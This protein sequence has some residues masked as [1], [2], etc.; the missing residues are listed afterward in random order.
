MTG[1]TW[2]EIRCKEWGATWHL[3][4]DGWA[5]PQPGGDG[6][7]LGP[8]GVIFPKWCYIGTVCRWRNFLVAQNWFRIRS[9]EGA[10]LQLCPEW[11][12]YDGLGRT[13]HKACALQ[14][15]NTNRVLIPPWGF[16]AAIYKFQNDS[17]FL[18]RWV[19]QCHWALWSVWA[20]PGERV[21]LLFQHGVCC[22]LLRVFGAHQCP[23][24]P[25]KDG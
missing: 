8:G 12:D 22:T 19:L 17:V 2:E 25:A 3:L 5:R 4:A 6:E 14:L 7:P 23:C 21:A 9:A 11:W 10:V 15:T 18:R 13:R 1:S 20:L 24:S 16:C